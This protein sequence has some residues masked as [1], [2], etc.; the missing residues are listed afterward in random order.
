MGMIRATLSISKKVNQF[1]IEYPHLF[2]DFQKARKSKGYSLNS[3]VSVSEESHNEYQSLVERYL[4][5]KKLPNNNRQLWITTHNG[6]KFVGFYEKG[7][8]WYKTFEDKN[9]EVKAH[10]IKWGK[11]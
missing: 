10:V 6:G 7:E 3:W 11:Y 8:W 2:N 9:I 5:V 1:K 4:V